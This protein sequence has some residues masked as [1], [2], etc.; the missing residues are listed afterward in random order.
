[1]SDTNV[2]EPVKI[3]VTSMTAAFTEDVLLHWPVR[4]SIL[5]VG[6]HGVGKDGVIKTVAKKL[7]IPCIDIRLSQRDVGDIKGMPFRVRG[8]TL[9]APPDWVPFQDEEDLGIDELMG[10]VATAAGKNAACARGLLFFNEVNRAS[11]EVQQCVFE[12]ILD[13]TMDTRALREGWRIVSAINGDEH[14]QVNVMDVAF[15]SRFFLVNFKPTKEEWVSWSK[16]PTAVPTEVRPE[17]LDITAAPCHHIVH[18]GT[19]GNARPHRSAPL[20]GGDGCHHA[21][22]ESQSVAYVLGCPQGS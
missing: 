9:F 12:P 6:D 22:P 18:R 17:V 11:R 1:M 16:N 21:G 13:H 10:A 14:Y 3:S 4:Q 5:L 7:R 8:R 19:P 15:K 20:T 2:A